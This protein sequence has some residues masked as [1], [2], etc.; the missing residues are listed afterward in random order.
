MMFFVILTKIYLPEEV[1]KV[2]IGSKYAF[3]IFEQIP[4]KKIQLSQSIL[5]KLLSKLKMNLY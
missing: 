3:N 4:M 5:N 1:L 2:I